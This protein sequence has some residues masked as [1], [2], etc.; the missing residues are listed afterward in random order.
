MAALGVVEALHEGRVMRSG[1][2]VLAQRERDAILLGECLDQ[3]IHLH[4]TASPGS[5]GSGGNRYRQTHLITL[6]PSPTAFATRFTDPARSEE[7]RVGKECR[8]RWSPGH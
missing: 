5:T 4:A 7:R 8:S 3:V 6:D 1:R 2:Y